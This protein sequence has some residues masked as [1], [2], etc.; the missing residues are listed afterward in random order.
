MRHTYLCL[1]VVN[2]KYF[3]VRTTMAQDDKSQD[4]VRRFVGAWVAKLWKS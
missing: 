2:G 1:G 4:E 3:K